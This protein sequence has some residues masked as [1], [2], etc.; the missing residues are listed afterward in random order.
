MIPVGGYF[1]IDA[2]QALEICK[3]LKPQVILPMHYKTA[4]NDDWT[5]AKVDGF[6]E[7]CRGELGKEAET[8]D[9]LRVTAE[10]LA[11]Q[12]SVCVLR[13]QV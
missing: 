2:Q 1:T 5:I 4:F 13:A 10:D 6:L 9:L 7:A 11:C 8:L 3:R 12:P